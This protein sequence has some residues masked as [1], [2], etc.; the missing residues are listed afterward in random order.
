MVLRHRCDA[1]GES[2]MVLLD[3]PRRMKTGRA[4]WFSKCLRRTIWFSCAKYGCDGARRLDLEEH[5]L[6]DSIENSNT[7]TEEKTVGKESKIEK[8]AMDTKELASTEESKASDED[9]LNNLDTECKQKTASFEE[10]Q[11]LRAGEIEALADKEGSFSF[12]EN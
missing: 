2:W 1:R 10:K 5:N 4:H 12:E 9:L 11:Q 8:R 7:D 3:L 6:I